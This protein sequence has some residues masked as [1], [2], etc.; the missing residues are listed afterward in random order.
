M[1]FEDFSQMQSWIKTYASICRQHVFTYFEYCLIYVTNANEIDQV[2]IR[3]NVKRQ[4][5]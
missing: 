1:K 3:V 5:C 4:T 2:K